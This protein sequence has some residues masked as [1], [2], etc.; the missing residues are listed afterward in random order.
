L[1]KQ[2]SSYWT[3][4]LFG[5]LLVYGTYG[6]G[7]LEPPHIS[8]LFITECDYAASST[9]MVYITK[10]VKEEEVAAANGCLQFLSALGGVLGGA[11]ST[12]VYTSVA[13]VDG[14]RRGDVALSDEGTAAMLRGLRAAHWFWTGLSFFGRCSLFAFLISI[15]RI[16]CLPLT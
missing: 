15:C 10:V 4:E 7:K 6:L 14:N 8:D 13:G 3:Y 2:G 1:R 12:V 16:K 5:N 9:G 11:L